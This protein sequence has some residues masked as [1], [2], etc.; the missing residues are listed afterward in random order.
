MEDGFSFSLQLKATVDW[1]QDGADV[2]YDL[3]AKTWND[4][5]ARDATRPLYLGSFAWSRINKGG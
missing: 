5:V 1:K 4:M 2:V 3:E